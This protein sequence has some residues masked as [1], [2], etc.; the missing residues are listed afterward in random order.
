MG[1]D[2]STLLFIYHKEAVALDGRYDPSFQLYTAYIS[3]ILFYSKHHFIVSLMWR[4]NVHTGL[5]IICSFL[6]EIKNKVARKD[7]DKY[8]TYRCVTVKQRRPFTS[9][10]YKISVSK[11]ILTRFCSRLYGQDRFIGE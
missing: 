11:T 7:S 8:I 4:I 1:S 10:I 5:P 2:W 9:S 6:N 3:T